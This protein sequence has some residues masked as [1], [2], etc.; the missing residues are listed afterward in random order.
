M[1]LSA[2]FYWNIMR[3]EVK[4]FVERCLNC[5]TVKY[6]NTAPS[7]L[8]Q[9]LEVLEIVWEDLALDFIVGLLNSKGNTTILVVVDR[10][11]KYAHFGALPIDYT[12]T[13][14]AKLFCGMVIKLH[15]LLRSI[16]SDR[17]P[18]LEEVV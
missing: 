6:S 13:K 5:Q 16:V 7:G 9:P 2:N 1:R 10:L 17:D 3:N 11:N 8:L 18:I 12:T 15:G 14:V 4:D